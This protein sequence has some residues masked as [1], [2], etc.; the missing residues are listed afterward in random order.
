MNFSEVFI[1]R[2][3]ATTLITLG[4]VLSGLAAF[5]LLSVA[6]LPQIEYPTIHWVPADSRRIAE[7]YVFRWLSRWNAKRAGEVQK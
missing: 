2:P 3:V 7:S 6:P 4:I 1:R 5:R